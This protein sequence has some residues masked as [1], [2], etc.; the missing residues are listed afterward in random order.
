MC[1]RLVVA[2]DRRLPEASIP[3]RVSIVAIESTPEVARHFPDGAHCV[4]ICTAMCACD[5]AG[6][7]R[8]DSPRVRESA[9]RRQLAYEAIADWADDQV[10]RRRR[11]LWIYLCWHSEFDQPQFGSVTWRLEDMREPGAAF[12]ERTV[13]EVEAV[14]Q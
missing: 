8:P 2:S 13:V 9:R 5:L 3:D 12:P 14:N 6:D 4:E 7:S 1:Y 10:V 11:P